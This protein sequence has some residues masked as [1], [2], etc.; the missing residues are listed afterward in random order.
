MNTRRRLAQKTLMG[1][2]A[3]VLAL[4]LVAAPASGHQPQDAGIP[5]APCIS[6]YEYGGDSSCKAHWDSSK[7]TYRWGGLIDDSDHL[8]HRTSFTRGADSWQFATSPTVPWYESYSSSSSTVLDLR[9]T[10]TSGVLRA[11]PADG[12]HVEASTGSR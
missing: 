12:R 4:G 10:G 2:A 8:G 6:Q 1:L 7:M 11:Q 3:S 5:G 9:N